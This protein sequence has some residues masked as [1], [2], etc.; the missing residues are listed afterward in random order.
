MKNWKIMR[1]IFYVPSQ[2]EEEAWN[3]R[4]ALMTYEEPYRING[5][6]CRTQIDSV[7]RLAGDA[8]E[9]LYEVIFAE[10]CIS[11]GNQGAGPEGEEVQ[12]TWAYPA[13][14]KPRRDIMPMW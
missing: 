3:V 4:T 5:V 7:E 11:P 2:D 10:L 14:K 1:G 8:S 6:D 12:L 9:G 13:G